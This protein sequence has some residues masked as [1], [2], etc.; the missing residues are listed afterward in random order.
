VTKTFT[1]T[2][3]RA[4]ISPFKARPVMNLVR[5]KNV[6]EALRL[7]EFEPRRAAPVIRKVIKSALANASN[8]LDVKLNRLVVMEARV[9]GGPLLTG[10]RRFR[11]GPMGRAMPIRKRTSHIVIRL[12]EPPREEPKA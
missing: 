12:G 9:D 3:L 8:D 6:E 10:G 5:G 4:R 2:H 1:A 11:P 7:L